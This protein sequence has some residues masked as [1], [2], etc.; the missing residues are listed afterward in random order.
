MLLL[1]PG[2]QLFFG[3]LSNRRFKLC[4]FQRVFECQ[5]VVLRDEREH[6]R[7][8]VTLERQP[9]HDAFVKRFVGGEQDVDG[10][11]EPRAFR[12]LARV[13]EAGEFGGLEL[14]SNTRIGNE[15]HESDAFDAAC[16]FSR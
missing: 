9:R 2:F 8:E 7:H 10:Y 16:M 5:V 4:L 13:V 15:R 14:S 12:S 6:E 11:F 1:V 3:V